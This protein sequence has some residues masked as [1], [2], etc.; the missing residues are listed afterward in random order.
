MT[1]AEAA[2]GFILLVAGLLIGHGSIKDNKFYRDIGRM[3]VRLY[4][5]NPEDHSAG[6]Q[7]LRA[8]NGKEVWFFKL[9]TTARHYIKDGYINK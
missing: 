4:Y 5:E 1:L 9:D 7:M 8:K 6:Y 2:R 3:N